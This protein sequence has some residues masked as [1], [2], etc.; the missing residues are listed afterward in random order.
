MA[1]FRW[2]KSVGGQ[3]DVIEK[4]QLAASATVVAGDALEFANGKVQ[5]VNAAADVVSYIALESATAT[6]TSQTMI[7]V[8]KAAGSNGVFAV[9]ITP[10]LNDV[11]VNSGSTTTALAALADGTENDL[12]GG[13][14]LISSAG[15][16]PVTSARIISANTYSSNVVTI[17]WLEPLAVAASSSDTLRVVPFGPGETAVKLHAS[18]MYNTLSVVRG[19]ETGGKVG[20]F[21]VDLA[22]KEAQVT[23]AL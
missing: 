21:A 10:L 1:G 22:K 6:A 13:I 9:P 14:V 3:R 4:K 7:Q 16:D 19:D 12:A 23:F 20:I 18:T 8:V 15:Q 2:V 5:R 17:T 11:A